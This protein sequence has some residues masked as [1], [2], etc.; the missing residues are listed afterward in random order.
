MHNW[1]AMDYPLRR[2]CQQWKYAARARGA[3]LFR[4]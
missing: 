2:S 3:L 1:L 4:N